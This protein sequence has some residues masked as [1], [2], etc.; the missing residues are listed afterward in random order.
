MA[1]GRPARCGVWLLAAIAALALTL[2]LWAVNWG[3]PDVLH[4]DEPYILNRALGFAKGDLSPHNFLYPTLYFYLLFAWEAAFFVVGRLAGLYGSL[5]AFEREYFVDPSHLMVAGRTLTAL[6]GVATII[7]VCQLG[8]RLFDRR[9]GLGAALLLAVAPFAV[10]D[11]HYIKHDVPVTL[12]VVLTQVAC[13]RLVVDA[14]AAGRRRS[15]L[16]AGALAGLALSTQYYAFPVVVSIL[17]AAW[18]HARR[19]GRPA[20][21]FALLVWAGI[22]S[23][24]AFVAT[25]PFLLIEMKT[26]VRDM[27]AVRQIDVDRAVVGAG[28]FTSVG[29]YVKMMATDAV[30]WPTALA[31]L[32]G[33]VVA[34]AKDWRRGLL[35]VAFPAAFFAFLA[36]TVPMS[37][38]LN[39]ML[40]SLAVAGAFAVTTMLA[41]LEGRGLRVS[42]WLAAL[43]FLGVAAPGLAGSVRADVFYAQIDTR[44][45]A[46]QFI[47]RT[48][49]A[50]ST[51]L[52]QPHGVPLHPSREAL[53]EALRAHL[54]SESAA[55]VKFQKQLAAA[56]AQFPTYRVLYLGR[57]TDGGF[58]PDKFYVSPE[59]FDE[60][61]GLAPLRTQRVAYVAVTRY[62]TGNLA[63]DPLNAALRREAHLL[64]TFSPYRV[65]VSPA[66]RAAT[67]PFSHNT[68]D[69]IDPALERPGPTIDV[70]GIH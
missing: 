23:V 25:S 46:R 63:L 11:A 34:L 8:T 54:G 48:A 41:M 45:L 60:R 56:S 55:S 52:V 61:A 30:G 14:A 67:A 17:V 24:V 1:S 58:D 4:P 36:N 19:T 15:W 7:A 18:I 32:A 51:V 2:R 57:V 70:W 31:A 38:Y 16:L 53:V 35:L 21:A 12:F 10:R 40:P 26:A 69:R 29:A 22:A 28:P 62:N 44:T 68:A 13:A 64:A 9:T 20:D 47:E 27:V 66:R 39:A 6:F 65:D 5:A 37:R 33:F 50:G 42:G 59:S 3:L 43:V 49:P